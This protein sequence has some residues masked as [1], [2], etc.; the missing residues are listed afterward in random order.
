MK[1]LAFIVGGVVVVYYILYI[2]STQIPFF[3]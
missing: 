2:V 3:Q 1:K